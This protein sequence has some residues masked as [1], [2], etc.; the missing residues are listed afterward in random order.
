MLTYLIIVYLGFG[1]FLFTSYMININIFA[2]VAPTDLAVGGV[3]MGSTF[4]PVEATEFLFHASMVQGL[5]SGVVAGA[6]SSGKVKSGI[7]H[8]LVLVILA[9]LAFRVLL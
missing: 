8:S 3:Q 2:Y 4:D 6:I 9:Y 7:K 5:C 1:V